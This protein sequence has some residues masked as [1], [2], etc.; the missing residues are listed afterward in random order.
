MG[1][2][3]LRC[4]GASACRSLAIV[5]AAV[6]GFGCGARSDLLE[7]ANSGEGGALPTAGGGGTTGGDVATGGNAG[8]PATSGNAGTGG[9]LLPGC[10]PTALGWQLVARTGPSR[11]WGGGLAYDEARQVATLFGGWTDANG[12]SRW[13]LNDTWEWDG[14]GWSLIADARIE[15]EFQVGQAP[16]AWIE[17]GMTYD[18]RRQRVITHGGYTNY[19]Q[20]NCG[21]GSNAMSRATWQWDG[22][23]WEPLSCDGPETRSADLAYDSNRDRLVLVGGVGAQNGTWELA[24]SSWSRVADAPSVHGAGGALLGGYA[25][26]FDA[27]RGVTVLHAEG[28]TFEYGGSSWRLVSTQGPR[29]VEGRGLVAGAEMTYDAGR[30]R[31]VAIA[32]DRTWE[33]DGTTWESPAGAP[34]PPRF[35][36]HPAYDGARGCVLLFGGDAA[37]QDHRPLGDTWT[38]RR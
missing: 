29:A 38:Y 36:T 34:T 7:L 25:M 18:S 17:F 33:W 35:A 10:S 28:E 1:V 32:Y 2:R 27:A 15:G 37:A 26:A 5:G 31:I 30:K 23:R 6:M 14:Q 21:A 22:A 13:L 19:Q 8:R 9:N 11:R 3:W 16:L 20:D 12:N 24:G 4:G